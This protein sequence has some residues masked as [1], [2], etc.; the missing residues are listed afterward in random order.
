MALAALLERLTLSD[1]FASANRQLFNFA[2]WSRWWHSLLFSFNH[3]DTIMMAIGV[4]TRATFT[5]QSFTIFP[6]LS[7]YTVFIYSI[8]PRVTYWHPSI[9]Y[10]NSAPSSL[11]SFWVSG[12]VSIHVDTLLAVHKKK[13]YWSTLSTTMT[14]RTRKKRISYIMFLFFFCRCALGYTW[15][16]WSD[17]IDCRSGG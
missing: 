5:S 9:P 13:Y 2:S 14:H 11:S 4:Q 6:F 16:G 7:L 3:P 10:L 1:S 15:K 8:L 17:F 12:K